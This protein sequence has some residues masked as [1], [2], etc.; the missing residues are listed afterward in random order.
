MT[1]LA[2]RL[3]AL[4]LAALLGLPGP[5]ATAP[6]A[7]EREPDARRLTPAVLAYAYLNLAGDDFL[8]FLRSDQPYSFRRGLAR[9]EESFRQLDCDIPRRLGF[10]ETFFTVES[11]PRKSVVGLPPPGASPAHPPEGSLLFVSTPVAADR[12][13]VVLSSVAPDRTTVFTVDT[14]YQ[15]RLVY[16]S[17]S[18]TGPIG[19]I[20][21]VDRIEAAGPGELLLHEAYELGARGIRAPRASRSFLLDARAGTVTPASGKPGRR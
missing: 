14:A 1:A 12:I 3:S 21:L 10:V 5:P 7:A 16:D 11:G 8:R 17:F 6:P 18:R 15:A 19:A 13:V 4:G 20:G 9:L 2:T